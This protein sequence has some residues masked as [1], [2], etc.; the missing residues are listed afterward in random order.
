MYDFSGIEWATEVIEHIGSL[1]LR[2]NADLIHDAYEQGWFRNHGME[3]CWGA[4]KIC[5]VPYTGKWTL[6]MARSFYCNEYCEKECEFYEDAV[7][8]GL[9]NF[10]APTYFLGKF[11]G[12]NAYLQMKVE[13]N[14]SEVDSRMARFASSRVETS[15][16]EDPDEV[17]EKILDYV[18]SFDTEEQIYGALVDSDIDEVE[19]LVQFCEDRNI[20]DLHNENWG[21]LG[22]DLV[23]IDFSGY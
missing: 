19:R 9:D 16:D 7:N 5:V 17:E 3:I 4:T 21:F 8:A 1:K 22:R 12:Y 11:Y 2:D 18:D 14:Q 6:K 15:K 13:V 23:L 20:N 10:F